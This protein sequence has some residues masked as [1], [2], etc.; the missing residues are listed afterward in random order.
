MT[1]YKVLKQ[2][3]KL[4]VNYLYQIKAEQ[5]V[6]EEETTTTKDI[7]IMWGYFT[8]DLLKEIK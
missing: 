4:M 3:Y 2:T 1:L 8:E 6:A 7:S 5:V